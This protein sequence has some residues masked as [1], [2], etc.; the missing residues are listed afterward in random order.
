MIKKKRKK[1]TLSDWIISISAAGVSLCLAIAG[2]FANMWFS[3]VNSGIEKSEAKIDK[4]SQNIE[5]LKAE[6][7]TQGMEIPLR[8]GRAFE[9]K[10]KD[11]HGQLTSRI[12]ESTN[13]I[14]RLELTLREK[15]F[16]QVDRI[17]ELNGK[18]TVVEENQRRLIEGLR[19]AQK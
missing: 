17:E 13:K 16:P 18:V 14:Q 15:I 6:V 1:V 10:D 9:S 19:K 4:L 2:Y 11:Y 7:Q 5:K 3:G 8:V 12:V